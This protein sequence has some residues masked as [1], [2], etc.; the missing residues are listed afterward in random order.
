MATKTDYYKVLGVSRHA[1]E[2]EI[3]KAY[4]RL[5]KRYHPDK[6]PGDRAAEE[7][8]KNVGEAYGVLSDTGKRRTYDLSSPGRFNPYG[9]PFS[10]FSSM[11]GGYG[12][13]ERE[14]Q[15]KLSDAMRRFGQHMDAGSYEKAGR[16]ISEITA[17][18]RE[19]KKDVK[20][21]VADMDG[22]LFGPRLRA[23]EQA[24]IRDMEAGI[25][26]SAESA[27]REIEAMGRADRD[28]SGTVEALK[29][30]LGNYKIRSALSACERYINAGNFRSADREL[31]V[32]EIS[33]DGASEATRKATSNLRKQIEKGKMS[34]AKRYI[35]SDLAHYKR[36]AAREYWKQAEECIENI[37][38]AEKRGGVNLRKTVEGL[39][40][41][42]S[43]RKLVSELRTSV[44]RENKQSAIRKL[45]EFG[46]LPAAS[47]SAKAA[48]AQLRND[49]Y[50][51]EIN[52]ALTRFRHTLAMEDYSDAQRE[53][54]RIELT[55]SENGKDVSGTV[56]GLIT[57]LNEARL[58]ALP[59][60]I[61]SARINIKTGCYSWVESNI[62]GIEELG[63][64][65]GTDVSQ[66]VAELR[67]KAYA[68]RRGITY[69][70][71]SEAHDFA[72]LFYRSLFSPGAKGIR[73]RIKTK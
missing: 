14:Y 50:S 54:E 55:G 19:Y 41:N 35:A 23:K 1:S 56:A 45:E 62:S 12:S 43:E 53:I 69:Y 66:T 51:G 73:F 13:Y 20:E 33:R 72:S 58:A 24:C 46:K 17:L 4:K 40:R 6:N 65:T 15:R 64:S 39:T 59:R 52:D 27:I 21:T 38:R 7:S 49:M 26:N 28:V 44:L 11:Y 31:C 29:R 68:R 16:I 34:A 18:G 30:S 57:E 22:K 71:A 2:S 36:S 10:F 67:K 48:V 70:W 61:D 8:F 37:R 3:K 60:W 47:R 32:V 5:A 9:D 63:A 42:L 25:Y